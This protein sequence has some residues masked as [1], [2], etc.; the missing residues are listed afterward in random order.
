MRELYAC[1]HVAEFPAQALLRLRTDLAVEP[2]VVMDGAEPHTFVCALNAHALRRG[3][4]RGMPRLDAEGLRGVRLL[5]RSEES[6]AAARAV[7]LE[8]AAKFSPRI[9]EVSAGTA[10]SLCW[11]LRGRRGFS[12]HRRS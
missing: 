9:E 3:A 1:V 4:E 10:C 2:V 5:A 7:V 12:G 11:I 6:E 8:R